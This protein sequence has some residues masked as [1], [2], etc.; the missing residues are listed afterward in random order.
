MIVENIDITNNKRKKITRVCD[1]CSKKELVRMDSVWHS[2]SKGK[3]KDLCFKCSNLSIYKKNKA[4]D[5]G[6][7]SSSWK[8]GRHKTK[9]GAIKIYVTKR[10]YKY[11]HRL[12]VEEE[13]GRKLN[14]DE[15]VHHKD[16]DKSN[17]DKSNLQVL[18]NELEHRK[19]H[20]LIEKY[21]FSLLG[22]KIWFDRESKKYTLDCQKEYIPN[23]EMELFDNLFSLKK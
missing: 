5:S 11:E 6:D 7:K 8:G 18:K 13:I 4:W 22:K 3:K 23:Y 21:G 20:N 9:S 17:N 12:I 16:M 14:C 10:V 1:H 19:I 15:V 2:R